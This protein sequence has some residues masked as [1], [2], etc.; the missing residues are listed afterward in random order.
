MAKLGLDCKFKYTAANKGHT[1]TR[2][3]IQNSLKHTAQVQFIVKN[4]H[5]SSYLTGY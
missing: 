1:F 3:L 5:T 2:S 4:S